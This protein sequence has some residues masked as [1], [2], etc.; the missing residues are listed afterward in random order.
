M[1]EG[2]L[3]LHVMT[4]KSI[5]SRLLARG[6]PVERALGS[7]FEL[8]PQQ[9]Q[10]AEAVA[11]AMQQKAH[12]LAEAGTGTGKSFAYLLPAALRCVIYGETIVIATHTISLQEQLVH[13]DIPIIERVISMLKQNGELPEAAT[14]DGLHRE[15]KTCL[16]K[17][18]GNYVS[19]R[20]LKL[21]SE[22]QD[23]L[24]GDAAA[25]RSLHVIEDWIG[26]TDDGTLSSLPN[27]ER[28]SVWD[29]VQSDS[30]NCMGKR[31]PTYDK[32]FY[33]A[34]RQVMGESNL[35]ICNHALFFSDLA[36]RV[37]DVGFL[38]AYDQVIFDEAHN[39]EDVAGEHFGITMSEARVMHL[40]TSLYQ[41]KTNK[42]YL[43][44]LD[45]L[46]SEAAATVDKTIA[47]V[48]R[49]QEA[50]RVF[51]EDLERIAQRTPRYG[52]GQAGA[53]SAWMQRGNESQRSEPVIHRLR[54]P[55]F[56]ENVLSPVMTQLSLQLK[57]LKDTARHEPDKYELN[58][59]HQRADMVS[60]DAAALVKQTQPASA[61]WIEVSGGDEGGG[62]KRVTLACAPIEVA[63]L[64]KEKLFGAG[65]GVILT[66]AT[67][68]TKTVT[69]GEDRQ[70]SPTA[71]ID[72]PVASGASKTANAAFMHTAR[73]L[74]CEGASTLCVGSPFDYAKQVE[75][76]VE[77]LG[78][79]P[80]SRAG[81]GGDEPASGGRRLVPDD[82]SFAALGSGGASQRGREQA[83]AFNYNEALYRSIL[84]HV[85][86]TEGGAFVLFTS[87][88]TLNAV[89]RLLSRDC[90][91][92]GYPMLAQGKDGSRTA[93][94]QK[95]RENEHSV[96]LGAA[97]FWQGVDVRGRGLRNVIITKLP[98]DP[99]DRPLVQ[100]RGELIQQRGG[101]PFME[102]ALPRAILKFKQGF[103]RLIRSKD[104]H[105]RVVILDD[106]VLTT[107]YGR[108]FLEA[109]PQG[110][111][112]I[113]PRAVG[114]AE[115]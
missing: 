32:C 50:T 19:V 94:L 51:F 24:F 71:E 26:Q 64:L 47:T 3:R 59:Y 28:W 102:D 81:R 21:A 43:A 105:G 12:L 23:K 87:F 11:L 76:F 49:A 8:R 20:R 18:R 16:V 38:P 62:N 111:K 103:G 100:A 41:P 33:Q 4:G 42:G 35:L 108:L 98:F 44:Q 66:S 114:S 73:S 89:S 29:K 14:S 31:C 40:L 80:S 1:G 101:S 25:R 22:R 104:D 75:V 69:K 92:L 83:G 39:V 91:Q 109:L 88:A 57:G 78:T 85:V 96:L 70:S 68:A 61:Y 112:I 15:L 77:K 2:S 6:G 97:S 58:S 65:H 67:L 5:I 53:P 10:M 17:G 60:S 110:V 55:N 82:E 113:T 45:T 34:A 46:E 48:I 63:P 13:K 79:P 86:A 37:Q 54:E 84:K 90:A 74:G 9:Q 27:I 56:V 72:E 30:G 52:A 99:P 106:R 107:R 93:I 7:D 95:F 36:L 115:E